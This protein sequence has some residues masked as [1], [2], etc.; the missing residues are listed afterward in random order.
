MGGSLDVLLNASVCLD[1]PIPVCTRQSETLTVSCCSCLCVVHNLHRCLLCI[2]TYNVGVCVCV[3]CTYTCADAR[4]SSDLYFC[5]LVHIS[6]CAYSKPCVCIYVRTGT[7]VP[8][9]LWMA[10]AADE[11]MSRVKLDVGK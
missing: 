1:V 2:H 8:V 4:M 5:A 11:W 10:E 3:Q 9:W 7:F 6:T